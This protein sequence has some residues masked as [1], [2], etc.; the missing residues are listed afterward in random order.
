[1][2]NGCDSAQARQRFPLESF[3]FIK[4]ISINQAN[5]MAVQIIWSQAQQS[6]IIP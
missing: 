6:A 4:T 2:N 5:C 3:W 1:M